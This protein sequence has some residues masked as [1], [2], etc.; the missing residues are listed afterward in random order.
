M[1]G[2]SLRFKRCYLCESYNKMWSQLRVSGMQEKC[3][4]ECGEPRKLIEEHDQANLFI[5]R[6][7]EV[8][9][10]L[11][12]GEQTKMK[13]EERGNKRRGRS[14]L[15]FESQLNLTRFRHF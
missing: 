6:L 13:R 15:D 8:K 3:V 9:A 4:S 2:E 5:S 12:G 14:S 10:A 1:T 11:G 7:L